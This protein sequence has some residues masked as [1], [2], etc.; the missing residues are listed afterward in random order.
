MPTPIEQARE[1]FP[2]VPDEIF[3]LFMVPLV[4]EK[5][6][7]FKSIF[8]STIDTKWFHWL[9]EL[10]LCE[11]KK[12]KW[13]RHVLMLNKE[14]LHPL[15]YGDIDLLIKDH[16]LNEE[17]FARESIYRSKDRLV[18]HMRFIVNTGR[19]C[20][21]IVAVGTI[22]RLRILDGNHR[23]AALVSLGLNS[24]IPIEVWLGE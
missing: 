11:F 19:L 3:E 9:A 1:M 2:D 13:N 4:D 20:A 14:I 22:E 15:S 6:W 7:K 5:T 17:T 16:V 23:I 10:S 21:P 8:D 24:K 18:G 12:L